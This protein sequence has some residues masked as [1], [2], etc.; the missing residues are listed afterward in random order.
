ME[1]LE[2]FYRTRI[3]ITKEYPQGNTENTINFVA[4]L[5][6]RNQNKLILIISEGA[7]YHRRQ[8]WK[9]YLDKVNQGKREEEWLIRCILNH[10]I[11]LNKTLLKMFGYKEKKW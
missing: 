4:E 10:H 2:T 1:E 9:E 7:T 5:I 8:Q 6:G 3:V 11:P